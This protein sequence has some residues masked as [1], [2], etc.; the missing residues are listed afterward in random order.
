MD[1]EKETRSRKQQVFKC[2]QTSN[3]THAKVGH[4]YSKRSAMVVVAVVWKPIHLVMLLGSFQGGQY[5]HIYK[6]IILLW[7]LNIVAL[8]IYETKLFLRVQNSTGDGKAMVTN[9]HYQNFINIDFDIDSDMYQV[10]FLITIT[11]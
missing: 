4:S 1:E 2:A 9:F 8:L 6:G 3:M 10:L 7:S 11:T 5:F